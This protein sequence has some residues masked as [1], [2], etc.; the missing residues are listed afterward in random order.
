MQQLQ[1][2]IPAP[3]APGDPCDR[4]GGTGKRLTPQWRRWW[5][6]YA[7]A[8]EDYLA[9]YP[10]QDWPTSAEFWDVHELMPSGQETVPCA[11]CL[12][13]GWIPT[14]AAAQPAG[15]PTRQPRGR[16]GTR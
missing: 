1:D 9:E 13:L 4:C 2:T 14:A 3:R 12:T 8:E 10:G 11:H 6:L 15:C 5:D 16:G 7:A